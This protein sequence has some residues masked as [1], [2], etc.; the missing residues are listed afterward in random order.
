MRSSSPRCQW[1]IQWVAPKAEVSGLSTMKA[2]VTGPF[3]AAVATFSVIFNKHSYLLLVGAHFQVFHCTQEPGPLLVHSTVTVC[4]NLL[5]DF[6]WSIFLP[7]QSMLQWAQLTHYFHL[8]EP[9]LIPL[10]F[11]TMGWTTFMCIP[12]TLYSI[13]HNDCN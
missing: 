1:E 3:S 5:L 12:N 9:F 10:S 13:Y 6:V 8:G 4:S 2:W 7:Q 11:L